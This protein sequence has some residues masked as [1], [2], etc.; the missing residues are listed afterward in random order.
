MKT[1]PAH[2][3]VLGLPSS[4]ASL[5]EVKSA[6]ARLLKVTRPDR[7]PEGFMGLR[8]AYDAALQQ[9][10]QRTASDKSD[11]TTEQRLLPATGPSKPPAPAP[12]PALPPEVME[13]LSVL[14]HAV[15]SKARHKIRMAWAAYEEA[16][17]RHPS[18]PNE[19]WELFINTFSGQTEL[20]ADACADDFI[21]AQIRLEDLRLLRLVSAVWGMRGDAKRLDEFC[22]SLSRQRS[23]AESE[24]GA[25]A[26]VVTAL[27]L[28]PWSPDLA[29]R[30]AQRAFPRLPT[31]QRTEL[32]ALVDRETM[33]GRLVGPLPS[34]AKPAWITLLRHGD[35]ERPWK[36]MVNRDMLIT[37]LRFCGPQWPGFAI[38]AQTLTTQSWAEMKSVLEM[39]MR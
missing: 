38:L 39:L 34:A 3:Q 35:R 29:S 27:A 17:T 8:A 19:R 37:L 31:S 4:T 28:G 11:A 32:T 22:V 14:R 2:W 36:E 33:I 20:L 23:L 13:A 15:G 6:Y 12:P 16:C 9:I 5:A 18:A 24:T 26:M 7:D 25:Y 30:L 21:L 10:N 1:E